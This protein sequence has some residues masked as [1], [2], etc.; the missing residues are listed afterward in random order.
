MSFAAVLSPND[1][2]NVIVDNAL[3]RV[4]EEA[5]LD[6]EPVLPPLELLLPA[7]RFPKRR[8][9]PVSAVVVVPTPRPLPTAAA[10]VAEVARQNSKSTTIATRRSAVRSVRWPV[11][12]CGFVAS[13]FAGAAFMQSPVGHRP[14]VQHAVAIAKTEAIHLYQASKHT[15]INITR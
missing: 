8:P 4:R 9:L 14:E 5:R 3:A 6:A 11:M 15:A 10:I 1:D 12:L 13:I 2:T 7:G